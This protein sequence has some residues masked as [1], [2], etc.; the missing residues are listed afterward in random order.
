MPD[1]SPYIDLSFYDEEPKSIYDAAV[2]YAQTSLPEFT[3]RVGTIENAILES[4]AYAT[5]SLAVAINRLPDGLMEGILVLM[6]FARLEATPAAGTITFTL[7]DSTG[8]TVTAGTI[9]SYDVFDSEGALT[10]Y[11][12]ETTDDLEIPSGS[13]TGTIGVASVDSASFPIIP[14]GATLTLVSTTPFVLDVVLTS[15][16]S[17]GTDSETDQEYFAR[18]RAYLASLSTGLVT[19]SQLV[20][21]LSINYPTLGRVSVYDLTNSTLVEFSDPD[22]PGYVTIF[23]CDSAGD[24]YG[25]TQKTAILDDIKSRT[26]AGLGVSVVD[27]KTEEMSVTVAVEALDAYSTAA[28]AVSVSA[29]VES[30]LSVAGWDFSELVN[31]KRLISLI[32][33]VPGVSL[34]DTVT[35][36]V[37]A[38]ATYLSMSSGNVAISEKGVIPIGSCTT[39]AV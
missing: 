18:G 9:V 16:V 26:V 27:M 39:T 4:V 30:Y 2:E 8:R 21:Y 25:S 38:G 3:P 12:F 31:T 32:A 28:V 20:N 6:G 34:V 10:Q 11:L 36:S 29:A 13:D 35:L 19:R 14:V 37:P 22:A 17:L 33:Q 1:F 23:V 7:S 5:S 15:L 24:P